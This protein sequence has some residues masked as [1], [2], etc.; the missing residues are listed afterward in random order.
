MSL[1]SRITTRTSRRSTSSMRRRKKPPL[2]FSQKAATSPVG[3]IPISSRSSNS[4]SRGCNIPWAGIPRSRTRFESQMRTKKRGQNSSATAI[5]SLHNKEFFHVLRHVPRHSDSW[6]SNPLFHLS[7]R[8]RPA[9]SLHY[10]D[11][12]R[13]EEHTSELQSLMRISYAVFCLKKK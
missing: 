1:A 2:P 12:D 5:F 9:D 6:W 10:G 13:S 4:K 3:A 7:R 8:L 11:L